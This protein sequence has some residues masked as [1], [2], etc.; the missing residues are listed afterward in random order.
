MN[1]I[2]VKLRVLKIIKIAKRQ[3]ADMELFGVHKISSVYIQ[4]ISE[5]PITQEENEIR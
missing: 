3:V 4:N 5:T 1:M 2:T